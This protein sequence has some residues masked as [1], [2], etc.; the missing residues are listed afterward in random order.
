M[1]I[2]AAQNSRSTHGA[3]ERPSTETQES[4]RVM[5]MLEAMAIDP[6]TAA[7]YQSGQLLQYRRK[8][9]QYTAIRSTPR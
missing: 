9:I 8:A 1:P 7:V 2:Q 6:T 5:D 4:P 3:H